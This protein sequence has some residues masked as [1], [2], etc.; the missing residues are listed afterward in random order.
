M[1]VENEDFLVHVQ[2]PKF[3]REVHDTFFFFLNRFLLL[4]TRLLWFRSKRAFLTV[5]EIIAFFADFKFVF[6]E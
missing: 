5:G 6:A 1:A 4:P 2:N 3:Q